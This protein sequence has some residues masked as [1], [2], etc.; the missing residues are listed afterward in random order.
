MK[1]IICRGDEVRAFQSGR[2]TMIRRA[3]KWPA[4]IGDRDFAAEALRKDFAIGDMKDGRP[5]RVFRSP[6]APGDTVAVKETWCTNDVVPFSDR[7]SNLHIY[8]A[9]LT[10]GV[11]T[12]D[13]KWKSAV[14]MPAYAVRLH[15]VVK[16]VRVE[17]LQD[18]SEADAMLEGCASSPDWQAF[19]TVAFQQRWDSHAKP[20][21]RW[22]DSPFCAVYTVEVKQ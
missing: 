10:N 12:Y 11:P 1:S 4:W 17:R 3:V 16:A 5:V 8:R 22:S 20:G 14:T 13:A 18:I 9:D 19:G 21:E 15:L 6:Y 7:P 2:K